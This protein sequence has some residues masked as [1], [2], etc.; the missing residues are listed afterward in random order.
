[1]NVWGGECL[2]GECLTIRPEVKFPNRF[3]FLFMYI[4]FLFLAGRHKQML[5]MER[6]LNRGGV[7]VGPSPKFLNFVF[8]G[9]FW[10]KNP[11][12]F[13]QKIIFWVL[14]VEGR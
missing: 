9:L 2:G 6:V 13:V 1:M 8:K 5:F 10:P 4:S 12:L 7:Q 14:N 3:F 11:N